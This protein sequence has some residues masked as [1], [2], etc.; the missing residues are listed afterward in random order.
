M[1]SETQVFSW[2]ST[3]IL[4][5]VG[6]LF[7]VIFVKMV[8]ILYTGD[9]VWHGDIGFVLKVRCENPC[10]VELCSTLEDYVRYR[11]EMCAG[12]TCAMP[13]ACRLCSRLNIFLFVDVWIVW[14]SFLVFTV[15]CH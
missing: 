3:T 4:V 10:L 8:C 5:L 9:V 12:T 7:R 15:R 6:C 2:L 11:R 13:P 14:L 1:C